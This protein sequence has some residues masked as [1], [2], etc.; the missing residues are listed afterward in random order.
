MAKPGLLILL[1]TT[2]VFPLSA[3]RDSLR[4][5][6]SK[7]AAQVDG[8]IGIALKDL[9]TGDTLLWR[10]SQ[11]FPMQSVFKL[12]LGIYIMSEVDAG[13]LSLDQKITIKTDDYFPGT[14]SPI[15]KKY[16]EAN[17]D[18]PLRDVVMYTVSQS[19]NVGCDI[20]FK[21]AGGPLVVQRY[22]HEH[23]FA[24]MAILN[25]ERE[26]HADWD[27]QFKNWCTPITMVQLID[28]IH[29]QNL[30]SRPSHDFLWQCMTESPL[31]P[32]RIKGLLPSGTLV[33]HR[34]G[35]GGPNDA[36][37][38]GAVNDVGIIELPNTMK[39]ALVVFISRSTMPQSEL[40]LA[41]ARIAKA[42]YDHYSQ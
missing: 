37:V 15:M 7:I 18:L 31:G 2:L 35:T 3:Q 14:W 34:T 32:K 33:G 22:F 6:I 25:T 36:G 11:H 9:Q 21:L 26:M 13:R 24:D 38:L 20:L 28:R 4:N 29:Q 8:D 10:G 16:P 27:I 12:P 5:T 1:V 17:V 39:V 23:G 42:T 41:I 19:D 40:E 30:L